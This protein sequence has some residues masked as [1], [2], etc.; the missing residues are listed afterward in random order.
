MAIDTETTRFL[1]E[2]LQQGVS[3]K[4]CVTLGRQ[5]Y[6]PSNR[7]SRALLTRW[8]LKP[9]AY[10]KLMEGE[11]PRYSEAFWEVLGAKELDTM[12]ASSF[13]GATLL[14]DLN[15]P[16]PDRLRQAYD[17][18]CDAGTL[19]HVFNFPMAIRNCMEMVKLGGHFFAFTTANNYFG[20]GFYQF[21]PELFFRV[22]SPKNGFR[23]E[24]MVAVEYGP[25]RRWFEVSDPEAVRARVTLVN[26]FPL[27]IF[28][29][30]KKVAEVPVLLEAPQQSDYFEVWNQ[31]S[32]DPEQFKSQVAIRLS[33]SIQKFKRGVLE[34]V[35]GLA[36]MIEAFMF[37]SWNKNFD[38][39]NRRSFNR[40]KK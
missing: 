38:F 21:S 17:T 15:Q 14:H 6:L 37:S 3:F 16:I 25:R 12:D 39:R 20:H 19:E 22:L 10:P 1:L 11:Y 18:V 9:D 26:N 23:V 36:R 31:Y 7:E 13:E 8:G 40:I 30:A 4:K 35:P 27:L 33:R 24:R 2:S 5:H 28:L 29:R 34:T 32:A